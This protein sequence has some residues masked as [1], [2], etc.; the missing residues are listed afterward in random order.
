MILITDINRAPS[1]TR[2]HYQSQANAVAFF[3]NS[4][5]WGKEKKALAGVNVIKLFSFVA[6]G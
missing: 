4:D 5:F 6:D 3:N 1:P 2:W